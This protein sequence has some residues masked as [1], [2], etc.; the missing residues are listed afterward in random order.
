MT[1]N[2]PLFSIGKRDFLTILRKRLDYFVNHMHI[3]AVVSILLDEIVNE[4]RAG[5]DIKIGNFATLSLRK[6]KSK[7]FAQAWSGLRGITTPRNKLKLKL[8]HPLRK[9]ISR[10]ID[11]RIEDEQ[12]S[13]GNNE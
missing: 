4:L 7:K 9:L 10:D 5:R 8:V 3:A 13:N 6:N 1:W 2:K 12:Q 11:R